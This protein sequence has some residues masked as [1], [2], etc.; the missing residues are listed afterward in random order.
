M[1]DYKLYLD[2]ATTFECKIKLEGASLKNALARLV[3]EAPD[4]TVLF[5]GTIDTT[6]KCAVP[7]TELRNLFSEN[8]HG[9]LK[10]EIIV[11]DTYFQPWTRPFIVESSKKLH[12]E[13]KEPK[14]S[15]KTVVVEVEDS[16]TKKGN[17]IVNSI[18][19]NLK[20]KQIT[21]E[22]ITNPKVKKYI[23]KLIKEYTRKTNYEGSTHILVTNI[24]NSLF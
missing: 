12:V 5:N 10:L 8:T 2:K 14:H 24:V 19:K 22:H 9:Q 4:K 18:V 23:V 17:L 3:V 1:A 6:G 15:T 7:I 16:E 21:V 11:D 20:E 13:V